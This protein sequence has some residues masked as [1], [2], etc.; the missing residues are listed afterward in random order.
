MMEII[1]REGKYGKEEVFFT[2]LLDTLAKINQNVTIPF[3]TTC[4]FQ[5]FAA[6]FGSICNYKTKFQLLWSFSQL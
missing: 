4:N 2:I 1:V 3:A 6:R 5:S